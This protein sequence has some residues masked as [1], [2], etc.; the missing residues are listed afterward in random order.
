MQLSV[1]TTLEFERSACLEDA[2]EKEKYVL[3]FVELVIQIQEDKVPH[4]VS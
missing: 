2:H 3:R 1:S 4:L